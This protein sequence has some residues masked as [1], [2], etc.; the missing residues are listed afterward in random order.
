MQQMI[1]NWPTVPAAWQRRLAASPQVW[2][3]RCA[4][5]L[6]L[7]A[8]EMQQITRWNVVGDKGK[9]YGHD[10]YFWIGFPSDN[11]IYAYYAACA[12]IVICC[13]MFWYFRSRIDPNDLRNLRTIGY[14]LLEIL[15]VVGIGASGALLETKPPAWFTD[16]LFFVLLWMLVSSLTRLLL[17]LRNPAKIK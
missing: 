12:I 17:L 1:I 16:S 14:A 6:I 5:L 11:R 9:G 7:T 15:I 4:A 8:L 2:A 13:G 10:R 3:G